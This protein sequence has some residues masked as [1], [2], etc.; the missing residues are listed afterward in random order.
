MDACTN[1]YKQ[2]HISVCSIYVHAL[3][4]NAFYCFSFFSYFSLTLRMLVCVTYI[5][6]GQDFNLKRLYWLNNGQIKNIRQNTHFLTHTNIH[7]NEAHDHTHRTFQSCDGANELHCAVLET[8][9]PDHTVRC[10][11]KTDV[12][13]LPSEAD[14]RILHSIFFIYSF[15]QRLASNTNYSSQQQW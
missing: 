1:S 13:A 14:D 5:L 7:N 10:F 3:L 15:I 11:Q 8:Q 12:Q 6:C 4:Y 9:T 2:A